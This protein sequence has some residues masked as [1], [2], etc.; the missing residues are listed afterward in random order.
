MDVAAQAVLDIALHEHPRGLPT[1]PVFHVVNT[2]TSTSWGLVLDWISQ[3][4]DAV[5]ER[6]APSVWVKRLA[7]TEDCAAENPSRKLLGLWEASVGFLLLP[8]L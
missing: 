6:V 1:E 3:R 5:F 8:V 7:D 2:D 4:G